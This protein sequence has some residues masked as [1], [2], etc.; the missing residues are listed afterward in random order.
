MHVLSI[1][2]AFRI[3]HTQICV[4]EMFHIHLAH[5][6][7]SHAPDAS[8]PEPLHIKIGQ[9]NP[10]IQSIPFATE[11]PRVLRI[12]KYGKCRAPH[13]A[14]I[15]LHLILYCKHNIATDRRCA[16]FHSFTTVKKRALLSMRSSNLIKECI[17]SRAPHCRTALQNGLEKTPKASPKKQSIMEYSPG[18][19][20]R[21]QVFEKLLWN[22]S[23][24]ASQKSS[25]NQIWL[26]IY[27]V[28]RLFHH[29]S[30]N[31]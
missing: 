6:Q 5:M 25:W 19:P 26:L 22:P 17:C 30:A 27:K 24:D 18:F 3:S 10:A 11:A 2:P 16:M 4:G 23:E 20:T 12:C 21:Y 9:P 28:V 15:G 7:L 1:I 14:Y 8:C 13:R 31:N 29:S